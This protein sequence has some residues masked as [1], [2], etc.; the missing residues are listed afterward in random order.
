MFDHGIAGP[1]DNDQTSVVTRSAAHGAGGRGR[2]KKI[3]EI[4]PCRVVAGKK[5]KCNTSD[6]P[7]MTTIDQ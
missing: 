5:K 6:E 3:R 1:R 7:K 4:Y 2:V